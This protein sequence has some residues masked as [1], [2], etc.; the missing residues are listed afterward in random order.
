MVKSES[1]KKLGVAD[2]LPCLFITR[3]R[4]RRRRRFYLSPT[5]DG[6]GGGSHVIAQELTHTGQLPRV[7]D[8]FQIPRKRSVMMHPLSTPT[9]LAAAARIAGKPDIFEAAETGNLALVKDHVVVDA[10]CVHKSDKLHHAPHTSPCHH[11]ISF[12]S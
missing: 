8:R 5:G 2:E 9:T 6:P 4:R 12:F 3:R 11:F 7:A 1:I 10:G